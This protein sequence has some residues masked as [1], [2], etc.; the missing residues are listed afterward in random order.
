LPPRVKWF[1][2][3][4]SVVGRET[5]KF[6]CNNYCSVDY[7]TSD[8]SRPL[9]CGGIWFSNWF[10]GEYSSRLSIVDCRLNLNTTQISDLGSRPHVSA[11]NRAWKK[12]VA[13][14]VTWATHSKSKKKKVTEAKWE[15]KKEASRNGGKTQLKRKRLNG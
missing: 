13:S 5:G 12:R 3:S 8:E 14:S 11:F 2:E 7:V 15:A 9:N 10:E 6:S 1:V 4:G